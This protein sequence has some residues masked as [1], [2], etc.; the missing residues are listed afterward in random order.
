MVILRF[1]LLRKSCVMCGIYGVSLMFR[2]WMKMIG[3]VLLLFV[4]FVFLYNIGFVLTFRSCFV[5]RVV[6]FARRRF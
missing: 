5:F 6:V 4:L 1:G 3:F 2:L